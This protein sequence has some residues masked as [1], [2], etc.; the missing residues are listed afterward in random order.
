MR[1]LD[2]TNIVA[3]STKFAFTV[4]L[5]IPLIMGCGAFALAEGAAPNLPLSDNRLA[6][7]S[8]AIVACAILSVPMPYIFKWNW[9]TKYFGALMFSLS[10]GSIVGIYPLLCIVQYSLLPLVARIAMGLIV[11]AATIRWCVRFVKAYR[12]IYADQSLFRC[13][14][15]EEPTA[16]F[17]LQQGDMQIFQKILNLELFPSGKCFFIF[18]SAA[19]SLIPFASS[20]SHFVGVPFVHVFLAISSV[21]LDLM[22]LGM[23]TKMWLVYYFYPMKIKRQTKKPVY[24]DMSSKSIKVNNPHPRLGRA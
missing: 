15:E 22:F 14:Y 5:I 23:S 11:S 9:E 16:V 8:L 17:Y 18:L 6:L 3:R 13:I 7:L 20:V 1:D 12:T 10:S 4:S 2:A 19:F 24:V 21:P